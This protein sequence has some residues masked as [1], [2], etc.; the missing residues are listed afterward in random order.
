MKNIF[1]QFT[2]SDTITLTFTEVGGD[3]VYTIGYTLEEY[4]AGAPFPAETFANYLA[5]DGSLDDYEGISQYA[6]VNTGS[7]G[8]LLN[9]RSTPSTSCL[10]YTS[11]WV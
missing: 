7:E 4:E 6:T 11:R 10:L 5:N 1:L 3:Q 8:T 9:L 2:T